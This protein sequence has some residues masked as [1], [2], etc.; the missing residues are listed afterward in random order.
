MAGLAEPMSIGSLGQPIELDLG[1]TNSTCPIQ[2]DNTLERP[3][4][5]PNGRPQRR[6]IGAFR[7]WR[8]CARRDEGRSA[9]WLEHRKG[10]LRHVAPDRVKD[11][12]AIGDSL[13]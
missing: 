3:T 6:Y 11:S 12:V 9:A 2:L 7:L 1:R 10:P 4:T 8:L 5:T 13:R